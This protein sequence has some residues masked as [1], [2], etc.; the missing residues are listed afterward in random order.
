MFFNHLNG[1]SQLKNLKSA[2]LLFF[3]SAINRISHVGLYLSDHRYIHCSGLIRINIFDPDDDI[4]DAYLHG[5]L[6]AARRILKEG[7]LLAGRF[8]ADLVRPFAQGAAIV[9]EYWFKAILN[10]DTA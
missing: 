7:F 2:D 6:Q 3:G 8:M 1:K 10:R 5:I 4:Y 9:A